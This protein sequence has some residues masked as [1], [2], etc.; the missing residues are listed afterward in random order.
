MEKTGL[1]LQVTKAK[2]VHDQNDIV[3][4]TQDR[5]TDL[6]LVK[7]SNGEEFL[8]MFSIQREPFLCRGEYAV[9]P[10]GRCA[11]ATIV[12]ADL[13]LLISCGPW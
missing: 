2:V 7:T 6:L 12:I 13:S 8:S 5:Y 1:P 11:E 3:E 4:A 10:L 9:S